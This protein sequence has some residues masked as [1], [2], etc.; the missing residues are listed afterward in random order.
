[1][2]FLAVLLVRR[3]GPRKASRHLLHQPPNYSPLPLFDAG[4]KARIYIGLIEL[5][6][7]PSAPVVQRHGP[8]STL[9]GLH[10]NNV[11]GGVQGR[12]RSFARAI[13]GRD[14]DLLREKIPHGRNGAQGFVP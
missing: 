8:P 5:I 9:G 2:F 4:G 7:S 11:R 6:D 10:Y 1:M 12:Q 13:Q 14:A 3:R